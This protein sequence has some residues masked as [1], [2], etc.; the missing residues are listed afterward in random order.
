M[1]DRLEE[2]ARRKQTLIARCAQEREELAACCNRLRMPFGV[3][4]T[5][6]ALARTLRTHPMIAA[7]ISTLLVSG[8]A[9]R[10]TKLVVELLKP[11][12]AIQPLWSWWLKRR[13]RK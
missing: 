1:S 9:G 7:G 8:Y 6:L 13:T 3:G 2:L 5:L 10:L 12:R 11:W 4:G